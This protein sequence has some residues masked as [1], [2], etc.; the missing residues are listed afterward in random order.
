M[1]TSEHNCW[2][3]KHVKGKTGVLLTAT[4][5]CTWH[6]WWTCAHSRSGP[7]IPKCAAEIDRASTHLPLAALLRKTLRMEAVFS[8][9]PRALILLHIRAFL[10]TPTCVC[11][12]LRRAP[13]PPPAL[14]PPTM[15]PAPS[16]AAAL[17]FA[18]PLPS[19]SSPLCGAPPPC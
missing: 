3:E 18:P 16:C 5:W 10:L 2:K 11:R 12:C 4:Y 17:P 7:S 15:S 8:H 9:F 6:L 1:P 14:P 19:R 13:T